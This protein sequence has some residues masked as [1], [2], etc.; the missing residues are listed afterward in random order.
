MHYA[1]PL[2]MAKPYATIPSNHIALNLRADIIGPVRAVWKAHS[3]RSIEVGELLEG[4]NIHHCWMVSAV[5]YLGGFFF[6]SI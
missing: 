4:R 2:H 5:V 3:T 6:L 1:S